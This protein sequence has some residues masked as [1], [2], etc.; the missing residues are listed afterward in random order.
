MGLRR[1]GEGVERR[2]GIIQR[3]RGSVD[4]ICGHDEQEEGD[5][6][7]G[8]KRTCFNV[9]IRDKGPMLPEVT[10]TWRL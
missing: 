8:E 2:E 10:V 9:A 7:G 4:E 6:V 5:V 3:V 1:G